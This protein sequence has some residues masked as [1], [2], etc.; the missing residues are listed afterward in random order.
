M[1]FTLRG[2][3]VA[4]AHDLNELKLI[5]RVLHKQI[6]NEPDLMDTHFLIE[7]QQFLQAQAQSDG[8]DVTNHSHWEAWL[9]SS[10]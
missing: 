10:Q 6:R 8:V 5:Y 7:L 1:T 2:E 9:K 4:A 3:A